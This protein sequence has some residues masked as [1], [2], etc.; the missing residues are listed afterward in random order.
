MPQAP[1]VGDIKDIVAFGLLFVGT[2]ALANG[3]SVTPAMILGPL[4]Q[5][6]QLSVFTLVGNFIVVPAL[7]VGFLLAFDFSAQVDLAFCVL[8]LVAGAPFVAWMTSLGKGN[9]AYGAASS[10]MLMVVTIVVMPLLLPTELS[11]VDS[12]ASPSWWKL[13]WPLL[14]F[15]VVPLVVGMLVRWRHPEFATAAATWL[16][17]LSIAFLLIHVALMFATYWD[18]FTAEFGTG[19]IAFTVAFA[20]VPLLIGFILSPPYIMSPVRAMLPQHYGRKLAAEIGT[21]QRGSQPLICSLIFAF[22]IYPVAGVVALASSVITIVV[23]IV[24]ALEM[25]KRE[26]A[27]LQAASAGATAA[28]VASAIVPTVAGA[29]P[30]P[31]PQAST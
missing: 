12:P 5:N 1:A 28:P 3:F 7:V 19:E 9:V 20:V 4:K 14:L 31:L 13:F 24:Y 29:S 10:F 17:P 21:A 27:K 18:D 26:T 15:L 16:G 23:M 6:A 11:W 25:G 8:A 2:A 30:P 22:G